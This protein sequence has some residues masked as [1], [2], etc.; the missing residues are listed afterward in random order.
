MT[1]FVVRVQI[2]T[3]WLFAAESVEQA[4]ALASDK[5]ANSLG[6]VDSMRIIEIREIK[7]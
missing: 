1:Y 4:K 5:V 6:N 7:A 2:E 3:E